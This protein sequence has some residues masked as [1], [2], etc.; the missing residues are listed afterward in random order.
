MGNKPTLI[1]N[2]KQIEKYLP[3]TFPYVGPYDI[4]G[5]KFERSY[6]VDHSGCGQEWE[7]ALTPERFKEKLQVGKGYGIC[8]FGKFQTLVGEYT[9]L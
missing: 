5:W 8:D 3:F 9:K 7:P 4:P 2:A 6:L 1:K